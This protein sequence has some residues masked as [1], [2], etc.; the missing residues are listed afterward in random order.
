MCA[1]ATLQREQH[2]KSD[3][4]GVHWEGAAGSQ[5]YPEQISLL[6]DGQICFEG[7]TILFSFKYLY[8]LN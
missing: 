7:I 8:R 1:A 2:G 3:A 4:A 6:F 5:L